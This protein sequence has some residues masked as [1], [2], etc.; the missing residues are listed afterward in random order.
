[1]EI[2]NAQLEDVRVH[3]KKIEDYIQFSS[4]KHIRDIQKLASSFK[5]KRVLNINATAFGGGVAELLSTQV[6]L[7]RDLEIDAHWQVLVAPQNFYN[8]TKTFHNLLQ[9]KKFDT[10]DSDIDF[11]FQVQK[12]VGKT[13]VESFDYVIV[14]DPQPLCLIDSASIPIKHWI[15]RCHIDTSTPNQKLWDILCPY[16]KKY[17]ALIF[18]MKDFVFKDSGHSLSNVTFIPPSIDPLSP[19]NIVMPETEVDNLLKSYNVDPDR[20]LI[21]QV[22]RFDPWKDPLGIIEVYRNI[23]YGQ[24]T[25]GIAGLQVALIGSIANDD[26]E[27]WLIYDRVMRRAGE[28]FDIHVYSNFHNVGDV[29]VNAFQSGADVVLQKSLKE[30]FGLTVA[31]AMW[32][33]KPVVGG[34]VGGIRLQ[35]DDGVNGFLVNNTQEATEKTLFLLQKKDLAKEMGEKAREKIL[36]N[37]L[38]IHELEKILNLLARLDNK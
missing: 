3:P 32:K 21:V 34:N 25:K 33:R 7:M 24:V 23:Q 1:M 18:T 27:G 29:A 10:N 11:Y 19:K 31:E 9:G 5:G 15:W 17:E 22:S 12:A 30:G 16:M 13:F 28:D 37:F 20:S 4:E 38:C 2:A 36:K 6:A 14:H 8:I 35:I 26:P